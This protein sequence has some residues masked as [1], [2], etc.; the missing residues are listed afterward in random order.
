MS[1]AVYQLALLKIPVT[2]IGPAIAFY[3]DVIGFTLD[4]VAEE[5]GWA[6]MAAGTLLVGLYVPG[7][8]GGERTIGGSVDFH[9][10]LPPAEFNLLAARLTE[11]GCLVGDAIQNG[12]D[13]TRFVE[14]IDPDGN[15]LKLFQE[16]AAE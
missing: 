3:R 12:D 5:Y 4:F 10:A 2:A 16:M 13:G 11:R 1:E 15:T 7:Q 8:G 9:L 6:Q 14:A